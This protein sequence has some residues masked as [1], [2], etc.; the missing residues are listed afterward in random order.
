MTMFDNIRNDY[1]M[2]PHL[3]SPALWVLAVYRFGRWV[4]G[5]PAGLVHRVLDKAYWVLQSLVSTITTVHLPRKAVF[6]RHFHLIH[7]LSIIIH[8]LAV[9]GDDVG[10]M[11]EVTVG[12]RGAYEAPRIGSDVFIGAG[13]KILGGV[14]IGSH[15][16]I[17]AN[18]VVLSDV[19]DGSLAVG[20]P[21]RI[22]RNHKKITGG[23][24]R[25]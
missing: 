20:V 17:G 7:P 10:I 11:H 24:D 3:M 8:P 21:A 5:L 25:L 2:Y 16:D 9:F 13:A 14:T 23:P 22:V 6:G 15:V 18:A 19:P 1:R 4:D 12:S